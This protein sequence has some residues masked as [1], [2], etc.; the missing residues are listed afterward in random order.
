MGITMASLSEYYIGIDLGT[1]S[2]KVALFSRD[3]TLIASSTRYYPLILGKDGKVEQDPLAWWGAVKDSLRDVVTN[4]KI[5]VN[6]IM[7]IGVTG[8]W[9][10]TIPIDKDGNPL[11]KA[12]IWMDTRGKDEIKKLIGGFPS[13]SGYRID[14][15]WMWIRITGGAPTRSGKDSIA[16]ILYIK[17]NMPDIFNKT[18]KFLD[19]IHFIVMKLTGKIAASW[20]T[21]VLLWVTD[22]RNPNNVV[23][24]EPLL[25]L[26]GIPR[27]KLPDLVSPTTIVGSI[28][29]KVTEE[30]GLPSHIRVIAGCGDL[31]CSPIGVGAVDYYETHLYIGTSSWITTHVPF[32]K[33]DIF[34]NIASLPSALPGKYY[35]PVEQE[36]AGSCLD[37]TMKTL[38]IKDYDEIDRL[39]LES[40]QGSNGLLFLP[41]LLGER[42]P[43]EDPYLRGGFF[44]LGI[45]NSR[46]DIVRAVME[47]VALN[48][49]WAFQSYL[50]FIN[51]NVDY[52]IMGGG[53][54]QSKI[55]PQI[56]DILN[57]KVIT[58]K[59]PRYITAK[60]AAMLAAYGL[61]TVNL[62][63]IKSTRKIDQVYEPSKDLRKLYDEKY[64]IFMK[65]YKNNKELMKSINKL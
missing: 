26:V 59:N 53:G 6:K 4:T 30:I 18:H 54:A 34:H 19:A 21:S 45:Y 24:Y 35:V 5:D 49:K 56:I 29:P 25:R 28:D 43:V 65:Y 52:V 50:R 58:V 10:D 9:S 57:I 33:T 7:A 14:K 61:G 3:G 46:G 13:I 55:W 48:I 1:S 23:Y 36:N 37:Y 27:D 64:L 31:P 41:W 47:G 11:Y 44:N 60:G 40:V 38:S 20:D 15:L 22:N 2:C 63:D 16:H 51:H 39:C 42:A 62:N 32:K 12:I 8:Q 17:N